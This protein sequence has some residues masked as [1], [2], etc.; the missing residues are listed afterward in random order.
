[1]SDPMF[2]ALW[3]G[4]LG[5][6]VIAAIGLRAFGVASTYI[7]DLLHIGAGVWV[8]GWPW[9]HGGG[10]P[11]AITALA[12]CAMLAVPSLARS[13]PIARRFQRSVTGGDEHWGGLVLY[14]LSYAM[15][16]A[17]GVTVDPFHAG[18]ALLSLSLGDGIGGAVGRAS[19]RHHYRAPGGKR[20]SFE[21]SGIV[22]LAATAGVL[23]A[24]LVFGVS[25]P[26]LAAL[27]L[28]LVAAVT[29]A[30]SPR[31][32]DNLLIPVAVYAAARLLV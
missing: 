20:K 15:F 31:G 28:G 9:W 29:E 8:L 19:G 7:R 13:V 3:A 25:V 11:I 5:A 10:V 22:A 16:T 21:G 4:V 2:A 24:G 1:M 27:A 12:L 14:T 32:T 6:G 30:F 26:L 17:V 23:G 18:A